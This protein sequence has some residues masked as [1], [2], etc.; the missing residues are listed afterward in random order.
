MRRE[1]GPERLS[2]RLGLRKH[3]QSTFSEPAPLPQ[4]T[5][6]PIH[7]SPS[8]TEPRGAARQAPE[9]NADA[10]RPK[11]GNGSSATLGSDP[12]VAQAS[13]GQRAARRAVAAAATG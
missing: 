9:L 12:F 13:A 5:P 11:R 4:M 6:A 2:S 10:F 8:L 3:R 1:L 7:P